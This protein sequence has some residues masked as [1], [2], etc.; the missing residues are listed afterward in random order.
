MKTD[1]MNTEV[2]RPVAAITGATSGFGKL[3]AQHL[4]KRG[5]DLILIARREEILLDLKENLTKH[6]GVNVTIL[7]ADLSKENDL[8]R[9]EKKLI[10]TSNLYWMIN[11]AGFG[12]NQVFPN[13]DVQVE[14]DMI[15]V[16]CLATMRLAR[17]ALVPMTANRCGRI[18][19]LASV[20]GFLC[21][22][23]AADYTATKAYVITFSKSLQCDVHRNGIRVQALCPGFART[24]FHDAPTMSTSTIKQDVPWFLWLSADYVVRCSLRSIERRCFYRVI[25]IPSLLYKVV[26][27]FGSEWIF[28]PL[29]ILFSRGRVR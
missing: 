18:I 21:G 27:F 1:K 10:E 20:A 5:N 19:N 6:Y 29:R 23:G 16:H 4:A 12:G 8:I 2:T 17:A 13:V 9:V 22:D 15:R 24:G 7:V 25:C 14:S 11:N 28:S 3:F 26:T